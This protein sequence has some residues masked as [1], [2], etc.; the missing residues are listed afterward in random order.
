MNPTILRLDVASAD[1]R[2]SKAFLKNQNYDVI[3]TDSARFARQMCLRLEPCF[4]L[5]DDHPPRVRGAEVC[6]RRQDS[7][8]STNTG[9][10][11]FFKVDSGGIG[12]GTPGQ[13]PRISPAL[14]A[15]WGMG[16]RDSLARAQ[17]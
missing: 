3:A 5:F 9:C 8:E 13:A 15:F 1:R 12:R 11:G 7:S 17:R 16:V 2:S 6:R 4:V 10:A 14:T